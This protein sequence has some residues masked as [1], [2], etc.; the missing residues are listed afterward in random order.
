[1][2]MTI[3]GRVALRGARLLSKGCC[4]SYRLQGISLVAYYVHEG[5][6]AQRIAIASTAR[7]AREAEMNPGRRANA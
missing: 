5:V 6:G 1:M 2:R 3:F 7:E 4:E